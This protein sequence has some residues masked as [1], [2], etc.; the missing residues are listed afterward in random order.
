MPLA[1]AVPRALQMHLAREQAAVC[2]ALEVVC[3]MRS[4]LSALKVVCYMHMMLQTALRNMCC[5]LEVVGDIKAVCYMLSS[6][7]CSAQGCLPHAQL[8]LV[9][10][11]LSS[12]MSAT[13]SAQACLLHAQLKL[14]CYMRVA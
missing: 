7:T 12:S 2:C 8:K 5:A 10:Y 6:S 13:C 9:C 11:M 3:Y 4:R 14:V 1:L